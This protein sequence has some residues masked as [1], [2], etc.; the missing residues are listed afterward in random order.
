MAAS[1]D[2][3]GGR[4]RGGQGTAASLARLCTRCGVRQTDELGLASCPASTLGADA[5]EGTGRS[6]PMWCVR[7]RRSVTLRKDC[8]A[9]RAFVW[10]PA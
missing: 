5:F 6:G 7:G 4:K 8:V 3:R 10:L 9:V 2:S 1:A